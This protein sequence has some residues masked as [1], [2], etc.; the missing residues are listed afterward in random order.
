MILRSEYRIDETGR[1]TEDAEVVVEGKRAG[2]DVVDLGHSILLP[3][4]INAHTHLDLSL[5]Q[6]QVQP[7][8]RFTDWIREIVR[9]TAEWSDDDFDSSLLAGIG[10]SVESGTTCIGD[11]SR[12]AGDSRRY[13]ESDMR[14]R[15]F[16]EV[17]DFNPDT[18]DRTLES[19]RA[20]VDGHPSGENVH[21]GIAPHTPYTVSERLL[22]QC[23]ELAHENDWRMCIHLAETEAELEFLRAG[24]GEI[25]EFRKEF[26]LPTGWKPPG[27]SP[28]RYL[29]RLGF[30]ERPATLV[31]CN[32]V[33]EEDLDIVARSDSSVVFCPR[34]HRYF[35]HGEHP[36]VKMLE[37]GIN[38]ALGTDSLTS[39]PTLSMLDEIRFLRHDRPEIDPAAILRMATANGLRALGFPHEAG[40]ADFVGVALP[41]EQCDEFRGPLDAL[42][43]EHSKVVFSMA[44]GKIL[45]DAR[46]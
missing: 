29:E 42:F 28:V 39:S 12:G 3:G 37:R 1:I 36:V 10:R 45:L 5:A 11:I 30:F 32:Y 23:I 14:V 31:H 43:S 26:G 46:R 17:I 4:F 13:S 15:L 41:E 33:Q 2:A 40:A 21:I 19:L 20:R 16:H 24:T 25:L 6:S 22:R 9:T 18:A 7:Q 8:R 35:G 34:S 44:G 38:F 27:D